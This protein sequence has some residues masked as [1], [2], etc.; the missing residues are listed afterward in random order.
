[1]QVIDKNP[2]LLKIINGS[3]SWAEMDPLLRR[4]IEDPACV[5]GSDML[6]LKRRTDKILEGEKY[7]ITKIRRRVEEHLRKYATHQT[8]IGLA[9]YLGVPI[10]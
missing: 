5:V 1:M 3:S 8:I 9:L 10:R 2:E 7:D 4:H 6:E